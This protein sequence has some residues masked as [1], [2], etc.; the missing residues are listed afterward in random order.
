[1]RCLG[2]VGAIFLISVILVSWGSIVYTVWRGD[3]APDFLRLKAD[4][5]KLNQFT[6]LL[7][8]RP[9]PLMDLNRENPGLPR[10]AVK[11]DTK[12]LA[13]RQ[14][15]LSSPILKGRIS[16]RFQR[17][18]RHPILHIN[19]PHLGV[20]YAAPHGSPVVAVAG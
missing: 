20:D 14:K 9:G 4:S 17:S 19:R 12:R 16:S 13:S 2:A 3:E 8:V 7:E 1:M 5:S 18:R 11:A 6:N 15:F 10:K